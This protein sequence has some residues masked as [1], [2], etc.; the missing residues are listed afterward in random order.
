MP[1]GSRPGITVPNPHLR[2]L[3]ETVRRLLDLDDDIAVTVRR[4]T[5]TEP[6]RPADETVVAVLPMDGE[7]SRWRLHRPVEHLTAD[8]LR[9]V[10]LPDRP[11]DRKQM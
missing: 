6:G 3:K 7:P 8:D 11:V 4:L 10:L 2:E 1:V 5:C 9:A